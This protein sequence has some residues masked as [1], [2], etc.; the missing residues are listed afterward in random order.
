MYHSSALCPPSR[1]RASAAS[2]SCGEEGVAQDVG[3]ADHGDP[4]STDG[5]DRQR[6]LARPAL[7]AV[8]ELV[9]AA[10]EV[11]P[12]AGATRRD[13]LGGGAARLRPGPRHVA[14]RGDV[15]AELVE[16]HGVRGQEHQIGVGGGQDLEGLERR[17]GRVRTPARCCRARRAGRARSGRRSPAPRARAAPGRRLGPRSGWRTRGPGHR[18]GA[19]GRALRRSPPGPPRRRSPRATPSAASPASGPARRRPCLRRSGPPGRRRSPEHR[20]GHPDRVVDRVQPLRAL[21][22]GGP[23]P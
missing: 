8:A 20:P 3:L 5:G 22:R 12:G 19:A 15:H 4:P 14:A 6:P 7:G 17:A 16:H 1:R 21:R 18:C 10:V 23:P 9:P 2:P 11:P 13:R